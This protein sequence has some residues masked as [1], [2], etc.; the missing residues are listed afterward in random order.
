M[1]SKEIVFTG[2]TPSDE[3]GTLTTSDQPVRL[4][5]SSELLPS[6]CVAL[7]ASVACFDFQPSFHSK[8]RTLADCAVLRPCA[9]PPTSP[10]SSS[11]PQATE[12]MHRAM[13]V[14][15]VASLRLASF[16]VTG[17]MSFGR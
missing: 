6:L 10:C 4:S 17:M 9:L 11:F 5:T 14:I 3:S 12:P 13:H 7:S 2:P 8:L 16:D 1:K 15:H